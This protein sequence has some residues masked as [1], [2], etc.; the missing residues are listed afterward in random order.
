MKL[1]CF[2]K[3]NCC[4]LTQEG[5]VMHRMA[6]IWILFKGLLLHWKDFISYRIILVKFFLFLE[7]QNSGPSQKE[8][9]C[10]A[11]TQLRSISSCLLVPVKNFFF[12]PSNLE[13]W[14]CKWL[15]LSTNNFLL[16]LTLMCTKAVSLKSKSQAWDCIDA[17]SFVFSQPFFMHDTILAPRDVLVQ[18][19]INL[20]KLLQHCFLTLPP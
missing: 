13:K 4:T 5:F 6:C 12:Y 16:C 14:F 10:S 2:D 3:Q 17:G 7:I 1:R 8:T 15:T 20:L 9:C 18:R 19:F 11:P